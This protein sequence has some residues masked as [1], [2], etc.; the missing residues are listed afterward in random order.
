[1]AAVHRPSWFLYGTAVALAL[2]FVAFCIVRFV[3]DAHA[4]TSSAKTIEGGIWR[5]GM[6][7]VIF[8]LFFIFV[9]TWTAFGGWVATYA[10]RLAPQSSLWTTAPSFFYGAMLAGRAL[11]PLALTRLRSTAVA[12][13]GLAC[14]LSGGVA[15]VTA[16]SVA[17][18]LP[19]AFLAGL[20]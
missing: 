9:G 1:K 10:H 20:G 15:L 6:L 13:I 19:G 18:V 3:P 17:L 12:Q 8:G 2:L 4:D 16:R 5:S 14:A 7:P 11:A